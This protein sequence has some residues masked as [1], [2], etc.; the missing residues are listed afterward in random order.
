[1]HLSSGTLLLAERPQNILISFLPTYVTSLYVALLLQNEV[2]DG[3]LFTCGGH[4]NYYYYYYYR[5][6]SAITLLRTE[7]RVRMV[8]IPA[9]DSE[10]LGCKSFCSQIGCPNSATSWDLS[11]VPEK[12]SDRFSD[13]ISKCE[14]VDYNQ[15][16][17]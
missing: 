16:S 17:K 8:S 5:I 13:R 14:V 10:D 2:C 6:T 12:F 15:Y 1:M 4:G 9:S 3:I 7:H 11:V